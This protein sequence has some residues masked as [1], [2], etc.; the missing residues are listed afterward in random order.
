MTPRTVKIAKTAFGLGVLALLLWAVDFRKLVDAFSNL[1]VESIIYLVLMS[2]VLIYVSAL[3]WEM[4][5]EILGGAIP[6]SR[7]F[8]LYVVGYFVNLVLPSYLG[9][10][11]VRSY[12]AGKKMG[13]HEALAATILERYTGLVAM[14]ALGIFASLVNGVVPW[15]I[16]IAM[17]LIGLGLVVITIVAL[18]SGAITLL[19]KVPRLEGVTKHLYKIQDGLH[20][21]RRNKQLLAKALAFSFAYHLLT[22]V[23]TIVAATA[24]GWWNPPFVDLVVVLPL[25]LLVSAIPVSP[26]GLGIQEGAWVFFLQSVGATPAAAM[27]IALVLRA[28]SYIIAFLGYFC[29]Q[30]EEAARKEERTKRLGD[31]EAHRL[32]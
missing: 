29:W 12:Y 28:K 23:N 22:V 21:A 16:K 9:G 2:V 15:Q 8:R 27:G 25:I 10:D 18:S 26:S 30:Y 11:A 19:E 32:H 17:I 13:Q 5:I 31:T 7:L 24:V 4:F 14:V 20:L 1:T 6:V 3:K